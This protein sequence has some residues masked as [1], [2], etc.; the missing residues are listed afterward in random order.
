RE[1]LDSRRTL[2]YFYGHVAGEEPWLKSLFLASVQWE[3]VS[4]R[5]KS[6]S[7]RVTNLSGIQY[8]FSIGTAEYILEGEASIQITLPADQREVVMHI[9]NMHCYEG[10]HPVVSMAL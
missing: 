2:A 4:E 3:K 6:I 10:M 9:L 7:Y 5:G 8:T 1:A